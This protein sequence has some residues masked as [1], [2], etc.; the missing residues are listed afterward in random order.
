[1]TVAFSLS[2]VRPARLRPR[3]GQ[4]IPRELVDDMARSIAEAAEP[5]IRVIVR[6]ER[7]RLADA[8]RAS[9]PFW[10]LSALAFLGT[11]YFVPEGEK[12]W[13]FGGYG[14]AWIVALVGAGKLLSDIREDSEAEPTA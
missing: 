3:L 1:M 14:A 4:I 5:K 7:V 13:K 2:G 12:Y 9:L 6:E 10:G 8:F 11:F